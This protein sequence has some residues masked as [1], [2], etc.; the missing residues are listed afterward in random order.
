MRTTVIRLRRF[1]DAAAKTFEYLSWLILLGWVALITLGVV[2]RYVF[3]S[4]LLFQVDL[5]SGLLA[6][7]A[8][9]SFA[10]ALARE[11]H[12]RVDILTRHLPKPLQRFLM[13][14]S[15]LVTFLM[16]LAMI[17]VSQNLIYLAFRMKSTF[18]VSGILLWPFQAMFIFGF[19]LLAAVSLFRFLEMVV[20]PKDQFEPEA[21]SPH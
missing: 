18:D 12:I 14:M 16:S 2:M 15:Y 21:A 3:S 8:S 7:F 17:W 10:G 11:Q 6:V 4:P 13:T 20:A 19:A 9:L 5:V 1:F